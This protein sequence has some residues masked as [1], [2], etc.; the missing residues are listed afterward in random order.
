MCFVLLC[1]V[2]FVLVGVYVWLAVWSAVYC[3]G[4]GFR[5]CALVG[6]VGGGGGG[7]VGT[8]SASNDS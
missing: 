3:F 4:W 7:V 5:W 8:H 6:V 2:L 1:R